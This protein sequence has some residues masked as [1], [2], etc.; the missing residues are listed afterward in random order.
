MKTTN[1]LADL[2]NKLGPI[3]S[4][5]AINRQLV[6]LNASISANSN[7]SFTDG[8]QQAQLE[9]ILDEE[10]IKSETSMAQ[11]LYII[12]CLEKNNEELKE[13]FERNNITIPNLV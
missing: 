6:S 12:E 10:A 8:M 7:Y 4:Y 9:G 1:L 2:R 3:S 5:F 13:L 11:I